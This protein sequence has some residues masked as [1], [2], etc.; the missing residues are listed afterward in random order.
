[1]SHA[2]YDTVVIS[3]PER[4]L[5][6]L[7]VVAPIYNEEATLDRFYARVCDSLE[8]VP[9]ELV[10]VDDG[11][12]DS[13]ATRLK[14]LAAADPRVRVIFLSRNFGHQ[15]A[16]TAGLDHARGSAVVMLDADLQDPP[17]LIPQLVR[18]WQDGAEVVVAARRSR[19]DP[20]VSRLLS[21]AFNRLFRR[22]V[23]REFPAGG[24]DFLLVSRRVAR[25]L[26]DMAERNSYIF[27]QAMWVGFERRVVEYD[28]TARAGGRSRWTLGKKAKYFV[29]AFTAFSYVPIR[30][31]SLLGFVLALAGFVYA[32]VLIV[33]RVTGVLSNAPG[34]AALAVLILVAAGTQLIV[35]G[36][37]GEYLWRV[38]EESRRRPAF[39]VDSAVNV[40]VPEEH[41]ARDA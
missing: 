16:L 2:P 9:F 4:Q 6:L 24:F 39:I 26:A 3:E 18:E 20:F 12:S 25:V 14:S 22:F 7:S 40:D 28:R 27:G 31:A 32:A 5:E 29:D 8:G 34:F 21:S 23:F 11:S 19:D 36:I 1:M 13:S 10:L 33:L 30:A 35:I 41:A 38:L 15:T 37:I 17:E